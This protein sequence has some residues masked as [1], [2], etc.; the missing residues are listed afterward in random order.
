MAK[1]L[2]S[3]RQGMAMPER[4][5]LADLT[6]TASTALTPE[7]GARAAQKG[8]IQD[9]ASHEPG[10]W[11][12]WSMAAADNSNGS[13][14]AAP[15]LGFVGPCCTELHQLWIGFAAGGGTTAPFLLEHFASLGAQLLLPPT[16]PPPPPPAVLQVSEGLDS[17]DEGGRWSKV[18][19][20]DRLAPCLQQP[21]RL[22]SSGSGI[23]RRLCFDHADESPAGEEEIRDKEGRQDQKNTQFDVELYEDTSDDDLLPPSWRQKELCEEELEYRLAGLL[24]QESPG[25]LEDYDEGASYGSGEGNFVSLPSA[26]PN[27]GLALDASRP[28]SQPLPS[29]RRVCNARPK[30]FMVLLIG[31]SFKNCPKTG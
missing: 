30:Q 5:A 9:Q 1:G 29:E 27:L 12:S 22:A 18:P 4:R 26:M 15:E 14:K 3:G 10:P 31:I 21:R 20:R 25:E 17:E 19:R 16:E 13:R 28:A 24:Q 23:E 6:N 2:R 7:D 8:I 11:Q